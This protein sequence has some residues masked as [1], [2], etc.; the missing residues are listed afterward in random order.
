MNDGYYAVLFI[1]VKRK[2]LGVNQAELAKRTGL[3]RQS[4]SSFENSNGERIRF[5]TVLKYTEAL[6]LTLNDL[7]DYLDK[8]RLKAFS[9]GKRIL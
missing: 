7:Q 2:E 9:R 8:N 3:S 6:G 4:V 5:S 1:Y